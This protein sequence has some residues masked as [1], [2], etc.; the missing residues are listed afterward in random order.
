I[1]KAEAISTLLKRSDVAM[2][3][4]K[5]VR[6]GM[7]QSLA[8]HEDDEIKAKNDIRKDEDSFNQ[9]FYSPEEAIRGML[10]KAEGI[11]IW[12]AHN[13]KA[14]DEK[15]LKGHDHDFDHVIFIDSLHLLKYI[16]PGLVSYSQ[17]LLYQHLFN[18][19]YFAH[20]AL[21][22]AVALHKIMDHALEGKCILETFQSTVEKREQ[23]RAEKK[24]R[25]YSKIHPESSLYN[26]KGIGVKTV[27]KL[28]KKD[29]K[30]DEEL[31]LLV[32]TI[33]FDAWCRDFS[34]VHQHKKFFTDHCTIGSNTAIV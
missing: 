11:D 9:L 2:S 31:L 23:K 19:K 8:R 6:N 15:V 29:I 14:F 17:P 10:N 24:G 5:H 26:L 25:K 16:I 20:H 4:N 13:G 7:M 1:E 30:T 33:S 18:K 32:N 28:Y 27:E 34:F 12:V 21:E 22:D 3:Y